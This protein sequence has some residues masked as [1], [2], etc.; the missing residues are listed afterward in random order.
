[1]LRAL[2]NGEACDLDTIAE[3][4]GLAASRVLPRLLELELRG[5]VARAGGGRF[6]RVGGSW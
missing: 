5:A 2:G 4:S 3:R 6:I 1:V